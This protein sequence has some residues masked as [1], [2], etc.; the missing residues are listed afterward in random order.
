MRRLASSKEGAFF[1]YF[2]LGV[3]GRKRFELLA[4]WGVAS[5]GRISKY[6]NLIICFNRF[7]SERLVFRRASNLVT[8]TLAA[9]Y[10]R[11]SKPRFFPVS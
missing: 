1:V 3:G 4:P 6:N 9:E 2:A 5:Q 7:E 8:A 10:E 11:R